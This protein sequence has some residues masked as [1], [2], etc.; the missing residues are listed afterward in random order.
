VPTLPGF[1]YTDTVLIAVL[2][3][4]GTSAGEISSLLL[5]FSSLP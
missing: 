5:W 2:I 3:M 1:N 4:S